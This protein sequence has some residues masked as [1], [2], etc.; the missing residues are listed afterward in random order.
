MCH[1]F[2]AS[3]L[4]RERETKVCTHQAPHLNSPTQQRAAGTVQGPQ[5]QA[6]AALWVHLGDTGGTRTQL[7]LTGP[8][9]TLHQD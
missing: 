9:H 7:L 1:L 2:I 3:R 4:A 6:A 5:Q 8:A